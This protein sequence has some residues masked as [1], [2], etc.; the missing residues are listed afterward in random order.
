QEDFYITGKYAAP[1]LGVFVGWT[2]LESPSVPSNPIV[3][4]RGDVVFLFSGEP[5]WTDEK[6]GVLHS[7][8]R[9]AWPIRLYE[10]EGDSFIE[11]LNGVFSGVVIDHRRRRVC[12]FNDRYGMDRLYYHETGH[13]MFFASEAKALLEVLAETRQF[14]SHG[15]GQFLRY[16]CTFE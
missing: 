4:K 14:D 12:L 13:S 11:Q 8:S 10:Q 3:S 7:T 16:G 1:E 5:L 2:T 15:I 6:N 9:D